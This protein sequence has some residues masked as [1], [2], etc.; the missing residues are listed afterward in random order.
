MELLMIAAQMLMF[1]ASAPLAQNPVLAVVCRQ[2]SISI[3][4]L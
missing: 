4:I 1:I 2:L 3:N